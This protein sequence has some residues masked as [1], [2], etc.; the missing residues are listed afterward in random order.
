[1]PRMTT[2]ERADDLISKLMQCKPREERD[3]A[4]LSIEAAVADALA[5]QAEKNE[6]HLDK[7]KKLIRD[8]MTFE[9]VAEIVEL[10][11]HHQ[12]ELAGEAARI[13]AAAREERDACAKMIHDHA[14]TWPPKG[15]AKC[16]LLIA[17]NMIRS[18]SQASPSPSVSDPDDR[19]PAHDPP[20]DRKKCA[21]CGHHDID[22]THYFESHGRDG[23]GGTGSYHCEECAKKLLQCGDWGRNWAIV[24]R[25]DGQDNQPTEWPTRPDVMFWS[26]YVGQ[27]SGSCP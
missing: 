20:P 10:N 19:T 18:R 8:Q 6:A 15:D 16:M 13:E 1:V 9:H 24:R 11:K 25:L 7:V 4:E 5:E 27:F 17:A 21:S 2:S 3:I 26:T 22:A 23:R 12:E 14:Q